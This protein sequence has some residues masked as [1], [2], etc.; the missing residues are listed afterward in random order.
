MDIG[1]MVVGG[2]MWL[3]QQPAIQGAAVAAIT[4]GV[5]KSPV[6]PSGGVGVRLVA[7]VLALAS[8]LATAAAQGGVEQVDSAV[9]GQHLVEALSAFLAA[10]G[11]WQLAKKADGGNG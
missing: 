2:L 9:V 5:K 11:A 7:A 4:E 10:V 8:V 6:G 1:S 3:V